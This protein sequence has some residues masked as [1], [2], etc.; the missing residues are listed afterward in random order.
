M[1]SHVA[2]RAVAPASCHGCWC[3]EASPQAGPLTQPPRRPHLKPRPA[4]DIHPA[5]R[6]GKGVLLDHGTGV[7]IGE[8]A[9]V[10]DDVSILQ[11]VTLGGGF[12]RGVGMV[13]DGVWLHT[14]GCT[15]SRTSRRATACLAL[16]VGAN[17]GGGPECCTP[18]QRQHPLA[19]PAPTPRLC[20]GCAG[21]GKEHGDRHPKIANNVLI[22]ASA[23]ILGNIVIGQGAQVGRAAQRSRRSRR[24]VQNTW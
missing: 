12:D 2:G 3:K 24:R 4:V 15:C 7:V 5:A 1:S 13:R 6:L 21:T 16:G 20:C 22:G 11:N 23:T 9:V 10:G 17:A 18:G 8:T 19:C 14:R